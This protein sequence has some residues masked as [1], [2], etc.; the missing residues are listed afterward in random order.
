MFIISK[1]IYNMVVYTE[2][3]VIYQVKHGNYVN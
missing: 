1:N 2:H 3:L